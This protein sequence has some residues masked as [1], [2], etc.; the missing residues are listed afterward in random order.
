MKFVEKI[1][2]WSHGDTAQHQGPSAEPP[3]AGSGAEKIIDLSSRTGQRGSTP[4]GVA[5]T[6]RRHAEEIAFLPAALEIIEA[7]PSPIG[8]AVVYTIIAAFAVAVAWAWV[9]TVDIVAIAPGKIIA[10]GRNKTVQPFETGVVRAIHVHDGQHVEVGQ[11]LIELDPT[12]SGAE[13]SHLRSDQVAAQ[14]EASRLRAALS[15]KE[16]PLVAFKPPEEASKELREVQRS[17]LISQMTEQAAKIAS[18]DAQIAQKEAERATNQAAMN[19]LKAVLPVLEERVDIR[20]RLF[21]KELGSKLLYLSDKQDLIGQRQEVLVQESRSREADAAITSLKETRER[22][23]SEYRRSLFDELAKAEQKV[24]GLTQEIIKAEQRTS[25]Q[26]LTASVNGSVQ[27]L[28]V[29]TV[30]GIVSPAQPLMIIVPDDSRLEVEAM[31]SNRDIGFVKAGQEVAI[32]IDTFN[33]TRYGLLRGTILNVS[34][35]AILREKQ[36]DRASETAQPS[37]SAKTES[38][39]QEMLFAAR[40][41]LERTEMQIDDRKVSLTPGMAVTVEIKTG[42][43]PVIDYLLSPL[44]RYRHDSM[45]ER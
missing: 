23:A 12:T 41:S 43:R 30:G 4:Q 5:A 31:V 21:N 8:R 42:S 16:D 32:K 7:P 17:F 40:V 2:D 13:L 33:F 45:R 6:P 18:I 25:L 11:I 14:L 34:Q 27:Q 9:G 20:E 3:Q 35:D 37:G 39:G 19:K 36:L 24:A 26:T 38:T 10:S 28:A 15:D 44:V 29:H 22:T 1:R